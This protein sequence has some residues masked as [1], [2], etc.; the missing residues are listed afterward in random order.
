[1]FLTIYD[2]ERKKNTLKG[3]F[4]L[5]SGNWAYINL[6]DDIDFISLF[7]FCNALSHADNSASKGDL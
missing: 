3:F 1:M 7:F 4:D 6:M 2:L 5:R